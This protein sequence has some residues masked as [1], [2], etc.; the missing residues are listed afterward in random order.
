MLQEIDRGEPSIARKCAQIKHRL[1]LA[2]CVHPEG[3]LIFMLAID[4]A[5]WVEYCTDCDKV[6]DRESN[7]S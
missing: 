4:G 3:S 6:T 2:N 1:R 5:Q 7:Y